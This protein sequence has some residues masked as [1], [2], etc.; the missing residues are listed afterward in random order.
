VSKIMEVF[1]Y[2]SERKDCGRISR[3]TGPV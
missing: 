3:R 1:A 2:R